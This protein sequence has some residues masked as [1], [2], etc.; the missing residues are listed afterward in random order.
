MSN[1]QLFFLCGV[2]MFSVGHIF[3]PLLLQTLAAALFIYS[4][5]EKR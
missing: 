2:I 4:A 1:K 3:H 5:W